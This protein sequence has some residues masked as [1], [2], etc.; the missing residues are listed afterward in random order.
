MKLRIDPM[1]RPPRLQSDLQSD[2]K[3]L[4]YELENLICMAQEY[5]PSWENDE[6]TR[7]NAYVE[8]F[9]LHCRA[10]I[11][12][13][14]GHLDEIAANGKTE[15]FSPTVRDNDVF[16]YDFHRSWDQECP[17]PSEVM[18]EAK[19]QADKHVAHITT[20]RREVNQPGS[21]KQSVWR[22]KDA[23]SAICDVVACFLKKAPTQNFDADALLW[24]NDSIAA[25]SKLTSPTQVKPVLPSVAPGSQLPAPCLQATTDARTLSPQPG[26][27]IHGK[28]E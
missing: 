4:R 6:P 25:W 14:Y 16:A 3:T 1:K 26:V 24:M 15:R 2:S 28:T 5:S 21:S 7:N 23:V 10:L 11:F 17:P 13:L 9:A 12:F 18:V 27:N 20:E 8:A 22:L 19:W